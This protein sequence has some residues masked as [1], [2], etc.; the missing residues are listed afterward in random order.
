MPMS[1]FHRLQVSEVTPLTPNAV[2]ITLQIPPEL[3]DHFSFVAGQYITFKHHVEGSE[4]RRAYSICSYR[5]AGKLSVGVKKVKDGTFSVYANDT[6]KVGDMLEVMEPEGMFTLE[7][8]TAVSKQYLAIAAG[9]GITPIMAIIKAVLLDEPASK[10][11][12]L[13]GNQTLEETMFH[14]SLEQLKREYPRRFQ[15][16]YIFSRRQ[17]TNAMQGRIDR[18]VVNYLLKNKLQ[19]FDFDRFYLCGPEEMIDVVSETLKDRGIPEEQIHFE[20]FT[21]SEEGNLSEAH[22]GKTAVTLTVDDETESFVMDQAN[23]VLQAAIDQGLDV[24]YSCQGGI[25]SSCIA[26]ITEGKVE[27]RKNQI[28]TD[29]ELAEGLVLTCQSHPTTST[30][31]VD[32]DDV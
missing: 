32:Y 4:I 8:D 26:R 22:D 19:D 6:L 7:P 25:C 13:Y 24:P 9:S 1:L 3:E 12:L 29:D 2:K 11:V 20:L 18:S 27:M 5:E 23:S 10:I 21:T 28:L 30:L 31:V 17:E 14:E 16:E 15:I